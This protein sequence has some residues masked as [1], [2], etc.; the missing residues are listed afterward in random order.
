MALVG[1]GTGDATQT[2]TAMT[3]GFWYHSEARRPGACDR[4]VLRHTCRL[5]VLKH[6]L[7]Q[8]HRISVRM[9]RQHQWSVGR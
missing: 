2:W 8:A 6:H 7:A 5:K 4:G 3:G 1:N 9:R